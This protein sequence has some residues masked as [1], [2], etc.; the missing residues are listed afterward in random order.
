MTLDDGQLF[1]A[2]EKVGLSNYIKSLPKGLETE[3]GEA[4]V[5]LSGGQKQRI[6]FARLLLSKPK[7]VLLDEPTAYADEN[8]K[9]IMSKCMEELKRYAT[10]IVVMHSN[11]QFEAADKT[12][13]LDIKETFTE[14][15]AT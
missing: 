13:N 8:A 12:I 3:V 9:V 10:V 7:I 1:R 15:S 6:G 4:G 14:V 11:F 5:Q 2:V